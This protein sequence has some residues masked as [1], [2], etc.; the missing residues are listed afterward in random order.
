[1]VS[2]E[3]FKAAVES[4]GTGIDKAGV[5]GQEN[6]VSKPSG[7]IWCTGQTEFTGSSLAHF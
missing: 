1:M 3:A 2:E 5:R 6:C 7:R 4:P